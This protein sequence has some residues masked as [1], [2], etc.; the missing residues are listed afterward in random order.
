MLL[1]ENIRKRRKEL[2]LSQS[3]L[4]AKVGYADHSAIAHIERGRIDLPQS[5]IIAIAD[6]LQTTPG[7]LMGDPYD[8]LYTKIERLTDE[9]RAV[10]QSVVDSLL[11]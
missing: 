9:Q 6:A 11:K 8:D 2:N 10:V 5:Q 4:A 3:E 7:E 1:Y